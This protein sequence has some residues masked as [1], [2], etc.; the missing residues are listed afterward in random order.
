MCA[1][2]DYFFLHIS[3]LCM[4]SYAPFIYNF[5]HLLIEILRKYSEVAHVITIHKEREKPTFSYSFW[6]FF[7]FFLFLLTEILLQILN[8]FLCFHPSRVRWIPW[9]SA[10]FI[11][12]FLMVQ[13]DQAFSLFF[14]EL[15]KLGISCHFNIYFLEGHIWL[16]IPALK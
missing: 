4:P 14:R 9:P 11:F 8:E 10:S 2:Q 15:T 7:F 5:E 3:L 13:F 16:Q 6:F 1:Y 12:L